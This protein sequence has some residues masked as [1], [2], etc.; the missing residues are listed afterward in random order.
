MKSSV[1]ILIFI[2]SSLSHSVSAQNFISKG[3][4][5]YEVRINN[6][7]SFG[8]GMFGDMAREK[9]PKFSIT[10][11]DL[12]FN[13]DESLYKFNRY[14]ESTKLNWGGQNKEDNIWFN[15]YASNSFV[16]Q[17]F[18]FDGLYLLTDSLTNPV[19]KLV[20]NET[21]EIAGFMCRKAVTKLF[22]SVYVF[23]FYSD[24]IVSP[25]GP[26]S[27]H[28]LPGMILG[29]TIP[30]MFSS[31]IATKLEVVGVDDKLIVAP[32]KGKKKNAIEL[33]KTILQATKD[34]GTYG[35]QSVWNIFM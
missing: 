32:K 28:G 25:G 14:D 20:P 13:G 7:K 35:Q 22:D 11:Y 30:R 10:Y 1:F 34:W 6:H 23:A 19:W 24:E 15:N 26:M 33:Q 8:D 3:K 9:F 2:L 12:Y 4:I 31:W 18:V 27:L 5:Q 16:Q 29:V 21:R 17:K